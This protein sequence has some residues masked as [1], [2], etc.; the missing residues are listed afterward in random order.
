VIVNRVWGWH[1]G[2]PLAGTPSDFGTQGEA[3]T[4]P[5][6]LDD[7]TARFIAH[8]WSIKWLHR[9]IMLSATYRQSSRA[10]EDGRAAD[11]T[12]R[13][14]W[15]MNPR[16]LDFEA[17]RDTLLAAANSLDPD[18]G[19]PSVELEG[20][21][22]FRRTAY[23]KVSRARLSPLLKLYDVPDP[24]QHAPNRELTTT[25]LQQLF[26]MNSS[27]MQEQSRTMA[28]QAIAASGDLNERI[29]R[30]YRTVLGRDPDAAEIDLALSYLDK[31]DWA[32]Y[33]QVL[34]GSN[35]FMFW[36]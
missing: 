27:F 11:P 17:W 14:V 30:L 8:G 21:N 4:H 18:A 12:N 10:R 31:A 9:E 3:P 35:E 23:A 25:P 36:P 22:N 16:R 2:K 20:K 19:G 13:L 6:L 28:R 1:F 15:R 32:E 29:R 7:L 24:N 26:V 34:L 5:E 33:T